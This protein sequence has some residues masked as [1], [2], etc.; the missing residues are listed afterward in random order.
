MWKRVIYAEWA[1][2]VPYIAF[3]LTFGVFLVLAVRALLMR[4][5]V[6]ERMAQLPLEDQPDPDR[7]QPS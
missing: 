3:F 7:S 5:K 1:D 4:R 6:A 2:V